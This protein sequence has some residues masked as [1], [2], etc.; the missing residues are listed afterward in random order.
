MDCGFGDLVTG[1]SLVIWIV[2][3]LFGFVWIGVFCVLF[4]RC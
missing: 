3:W 1:Y 2:V 4:A